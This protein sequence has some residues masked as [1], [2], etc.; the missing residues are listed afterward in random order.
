MPIDFKQV[1]APSFS[2]ANELLKLAQEQRQAA[3]TGIV[4]TVNTGFANIQDSNHAQMLNLLNMQT[5]EQMLDP[6]YQQELNQKFK[7]IAAPSGG[8]YDPLAIEAMRDAAIDKD[9]KREDAM[10]SNSLGN[11][12]VQDKKIDVKKNTIELAGDKRVEEE[13]VATA[14]AA[15]LDA[16]KQDIAKQYMFLTSKVN[17]AS[18]PEDALRYQG[19]LDALGTSLAEKG[20]YGYMQDV[21]SIIGQFGIDQDNVAFEKAKQD[22]FIRNSNQ[23]YTHKNNADERLN[24]GTQLAVRSSD[25]ADGRLAFDMYKYEDGKGGVDQKALETAVGAAG[26]SNGEVNLQDGTLRPEAVRA[27]VGGRIEA[28]RNSIYNPLIN[29]EGKSETFASKL[30]ANRK[31]ILANSPYMNE[32]KMGQITKKLNSFR[33]KDGKGNVVSTLNET[34]KWEVMQAI[35]SGVIPTERWSTVSVGGLS[36]YEALLDKNITN[37][38]KWL[39]ET[40][41][42]AELDK[43]KRDVY[44]AEVQKIIKTFPNSDHKQAAEILGLDDPKGKDYHLY[45]SYIHDIYG[46]PQNGKQFKVNTQADFVPISEDTVE[47]K[48]KPRG[49]LGKMDD[50]AKAA[51]IMGLVTLNSLGGGKKKEEGKED[52]PSTPSTPYGVLRK[53]ILGF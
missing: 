41:K 46:P 34:D 29:A 47:N 33:G 40:H 18:T 3:M 12:N 25:R 17:S 14:A 20:D 52:K 5:R 39:N 37:Y 48:G 22:I 27:T 32:N 6:V 4:D 16:E 43:Y 51:Q 15:K 28:K 9:R 50:A 42:P 31:D 36:N 44:N 38:V 7:D 49:V 19:E 21:A 35:A 11:L 24:V 10:W 45:P 30:A 8:I 26:Y 23:Q 2:G 13:A 53:T 1:A